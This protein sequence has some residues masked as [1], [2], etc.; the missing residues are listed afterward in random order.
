MKL[1][2]VAVGA[3]LLPGAASAQ[4]SPELGR[5]ATP[6]GGAGETVGARSGWQQVRDAD[7]HM[8]EADYRALL[9]QELTRAEQMVGK[10]LTERDRSKIRGQVRSDLIAWRRQYDLRSTDYNAMRERWLVEEGSLS[11][12]AWAKQRVD[13]LRAQATWI[14]A[15]E[16]Q[17]AVRAR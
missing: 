9:A 4:S 1:T 8:R 15:N 6:Q 2:V 11:P 10:P 17:P 5:T 3:L 12:E 7:G 14:L 13:W 16:G